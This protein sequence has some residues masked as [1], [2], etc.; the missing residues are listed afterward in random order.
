MSV[1][2]T[3]VT[4]LTLQDRKGFKTKQISYNV[5]P[6]IYAKFVLKPFP[7]SM[8]DSGDVSPL[9]RS[10][11]SVL[12]S[13]S[14]PVKSLSSV[15]LSESSPVRS[16]SSVLLSESSP[17]RSL[18]SV[19]L[20]ESS[21]LLVLLSLSFLL[22]VWVRER[23][24]DLARR[25]V[26]VRCKNCN[27]GR[28]KLTLGDEVPQTQIERKLNVLTTTSKPTKTDLDYLLV[29]QPQRTY[30]LQDLVP[31]SFFVE[32]NTFQY[33]E[34]P[35]PLTY[36][37]FLVRKFNLKPVQPVIQS[38]PQLTFEREK[39]QLVREGS[40]RSQVWDQ[41]ERDGSLKEDDPGSGWRSS[42]DWVR[43]WIQ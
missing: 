36:Q 27:N 34:D 19:L 32:E 3:G 14:S 37:T 17:V 5:K 11:S 42:S 2:M 35:R 8:F 13:E 29:T 31:P 30:R 41:V 1:V 21:V 24:G 12:R 4:S 7:C 25:S 38:N 15:L 40:T 43:H 22:G 33:F 39:G 18:S 26:S 10:L 6:N 20:S 16:L 23:G 28:P 9:L